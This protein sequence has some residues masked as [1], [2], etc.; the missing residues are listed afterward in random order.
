[1]K[2]R[3]LARYAL[4]P[5]LFALAACGGTGPIPTPTPTPAPI[6]TSIPT[7]TP[8][9]GGSGISGTVS[10]PTGEVLGTAILACYSESCDPA[11]D[12]NSSATQVTTSGASAPYNIAVAAGTYAVVALQDTNGNG[13]FET[14][15]YAG[16]YPSAVTAPASGINIV[17]EPY[18]ATAG[19]REGWRRLLQN[20]TKY[21]F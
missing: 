1:M 17:M 9:P 15:D 12:G 16:V 19:A 2:I 5:L 13:A 4:V 21:G 7:P 18:T 11:T 14:G 10:S 8:T 3:S 6:P 20:G